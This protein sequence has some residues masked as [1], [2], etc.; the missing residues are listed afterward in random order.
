M[1]MAEGYLSGRELNAVIEMYAAAVTS[2]FA[3]GVPNIR[4]I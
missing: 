1:I 2:V 3:V 4:P